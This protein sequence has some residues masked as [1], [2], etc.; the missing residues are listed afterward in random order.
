M[1]LLPAPEPSTYITLLLIHV[2]LYH[3]L[4]LYKH[5]HYF[6]ETKRIPTYPLTVHSSSKLIHKNQKRSHFGVGRSYGWEG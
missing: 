1:L 4:V 5:T 3:T 6:E 2:M